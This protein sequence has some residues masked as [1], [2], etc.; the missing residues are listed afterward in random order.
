VLGRAPTDVEIAEESGLPLAQVEGVR[1]A[2][3]AVTSLDRPLGEEGGE[4]LRG[5][6]PAE[7]GAEPFEEVHVSLLGTALRAAAGALPELERQ[8]IE[9]RYFEEPPLSLICD[10]TEARR[11]PRA[12]EATRGVSAR[13]PLARAG[14]AVPAG[15]GRS[16]PGGQP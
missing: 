6:I 14:A 13:P 3:R 16:R 1:R 4:T 8:V 2:A 12:G 9:L 15:D 11:H 5:V 7:E 10:R